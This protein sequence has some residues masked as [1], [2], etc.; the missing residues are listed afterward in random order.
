MYSNEKPFCFLCYYNKY[1]NIY[2]TRSIFIIT[3]KILYIF[4]F[5][6]LQGGRSVTLLYILK[7]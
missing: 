5:N 2:Y 1:N 7:D 6:I 4:L 3:L